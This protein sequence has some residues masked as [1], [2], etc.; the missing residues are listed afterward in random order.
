MTGMELSTALRYNLNPIVVVLNN[1]I[2][3]TEQLMLEGAFNDLQHWDYSSLPKVI[4]GGQGFQIETEDHFNNALTFALA[5]KN[6]YSI[7]DVHLERDDRSPALD[8][9]TKNIA[10]QFYIHH[11]AKRV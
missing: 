5:H 11:D 2:Y 8:R 9:L 1:G 4:G 3:L 7:L 6:T 10:K